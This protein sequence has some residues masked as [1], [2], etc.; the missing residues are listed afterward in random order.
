MT[1]D[2]RSRKA[3]LKRIAK[4]AMDNNIHPEIHGWFKENDKWCLCDGYRFVRLKDKV[5]IEIEDA[6]GMNLQQFVGELK[7]EIVLPDMEE[8]K[9]WIKDK[10]TKNKPFRFHYGDYKY[11]LVN[12][13]YLKDMLDIFGQPFCNIC[14]TSYFETLYFVGDDGDG[15][16]LPIR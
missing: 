8:L 11:I 15:I 12:A 7:E 16:L 5:D 6:T 13:S 2:G 1:V 14:Q 9:A 3:A 10:V 4:Q